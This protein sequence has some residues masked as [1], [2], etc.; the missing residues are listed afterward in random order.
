MRIRHAQFLALINIGCAAH[1]MNRR[2]QHFGAFSPIGRVAA[3]PAD[4][5]R[6]VV[7][8]PKQSVPAAVFLH[9]L[10]PGLEQ[11]L[12]RPMVGGHQ[13]PFLPVFIVHFQVMEVEAHRQ[14]MVFL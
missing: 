8:A 14:F 1:T 11:T 12:Q 13:L 10:L 3:E 6:L 9:S 5:T 4:G 7:I 2:G